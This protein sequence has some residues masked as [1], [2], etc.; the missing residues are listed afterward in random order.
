VQPETDI[1]DIA[2]LPGV[3]RRLRAAGCVFAEDEA[4]LLLTEADGPA[5]LADMV[6][7]RVAG[8]PLEQVLGWAAFYGLRVAVEPGVFVPRRRTEVLVEEALRRV[9]P[10]AVVVDLCCGTG[11]VG[12]ALLRAVPDLDVYAV[13]I[14]PAAVHC[15]RRNLPADRVLEGDL[16][17]VLPQGL[18]GRVAALVVNAPYVP[19]EEIAMMP[20][21]AR[22]HEARVALDGGV[23]GLDLHRRVAAGA[24]EWLGPSGHLVVETS[25]R[26]A[27]GTADAFSRNRLD[28]EVVRDEDRGATVVVGRRTA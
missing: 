19:T 17:S 7:R 16:Y 6:E 20:A 11:A 10:A 18:R 24:H 14:D 28:P 3:V 22:D 27:P 8:A 5:Q 12:A 26:Q 1:T 2:P 4:D 15:A 9:G 25:T 23:D 13:D 21:E